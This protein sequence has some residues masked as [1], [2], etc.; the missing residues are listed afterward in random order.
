MHCLFMIIY[1]NRRSTFGMK[2][3][4][5][6]LKADANSSLQLSRRKVPPKEK[7]SR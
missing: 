7:V 5:S 6:L 2:R 3:A 1:N 4:V